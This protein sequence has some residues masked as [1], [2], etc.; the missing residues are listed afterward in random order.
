MTTDSSAEPP[1]LNTPD[2]ISAIL[3]AIQAGELRP[4]DQVPTNAQLAAR[5]G[6]HRNTASKA[7]HHLKSTGVLSGPAGGKTWVRVPPPVTVRRNTRYH[8]EL[9]AIEKPEAERAVLGVSETDTGI[10]ISDLHENGAKYDKVEGPGPLC[11]IF[12]IP[13][14]S[15]L[16]RRTYTRRHVEFA[17]ISRST[18]YL[19]YD[20]VKDHPDLLD[21][22]KEPWPG[23]TMHQLASIGIQVGKI[24]EWVTCTMPTTDEMGDYDIPPGVPIVNIQK[25]TYDTAGRV[26]EIAEIPLAGD[27]T[28]LV[29]TTELRA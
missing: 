14:G 29:Y 19:P 9:A 8:D 25:R 24:V 12:D 17:G 27:R 20:L 7:V 10:S 23:G 11:E 3:A 4:G 2:V 5:Y 16:L 13:T 18:S 28:T 21:S 6:V 1:I 26:V 22:T 15:F